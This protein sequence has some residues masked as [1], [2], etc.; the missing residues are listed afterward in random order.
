MSVGH[1]QFDGVFG[2][3]DLTSF[4]RRYQWNED[5]ELVVPRRPE[6]VESSEPPSAGSLGN[7]QNEIASDLM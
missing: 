2:A 1:P 7:W 4:S 5:I 3:T 6:F